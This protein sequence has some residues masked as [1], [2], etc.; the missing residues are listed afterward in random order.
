MTD[1]TFE[2]HYTINEL[3]EIWGWSHETIRRRIK[4]EPG[5]LKKP[6]RVP[7][8]VARRVHLKYTNK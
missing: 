1:T 6:Y 2:R 7:E 5:V 8:S 3:M 4:D